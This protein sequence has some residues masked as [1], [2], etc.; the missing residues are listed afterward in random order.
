MNYTKN[1]P[2]LDL[3]VGRCGGAPR[4]SRSQLYRS[5]FLELPRQ[6]WG[7]PC[8]QRKNSRCSILKSC[9]SALCVGVPVS[10][11]PRRS[12]ITSCFSVENAWLSPQWIQIDWTLAVGKETKAD[13]IGLEISHLV[14]A[15]NAS[16]LST[17][18]SRIVIPKQ[19]GLQNGLLNRTPF[20]CHYESVTS[21][22]MSMFFLYLEKKNS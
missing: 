13:F 17:T 16:Q 3:C 8:P 1:K 5:R 22:Q 9:W 19:N 4:R 2:R 6:I 11:R 21:I 20:T 14:Q 10:T 15:R 7:C 12:P 18:L